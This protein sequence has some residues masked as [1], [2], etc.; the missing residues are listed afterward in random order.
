MFQ[1]EPKG[2]SIASHGKNELEETLRA[3]TK[4][5]NQAIRR[6]HPKK[7]TQLI[8]IALRNFGQKPLDTCS[9]LS[10]NAA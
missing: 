5:K 7:A 10:G 9:E 3:E 2:G 4:K 6:I 8:A 1:F